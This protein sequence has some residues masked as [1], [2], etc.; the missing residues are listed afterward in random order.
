M[1]E[2]ACATRSVN[3]TAEGWASPAGS[4]F[5]L[6]TFINNSVGNVCMRTSYAPT[7]LFCD[8]ELIKARAPGWLPQDNG[9]SRNELFIS[10]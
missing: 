2:E 4:H 1:E 10:A 9:T 5:A 8:R 7:G 3:S 6:N